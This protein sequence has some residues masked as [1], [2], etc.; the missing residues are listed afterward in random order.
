M[1]ESTELA[2]T[3]VT[4]IQMLESTELAPTRV[5][6]IQMLESTELAPTRVT[7]IQMLESTE[8]APTRVTE[9]QMLGEKTNFHESHG[10]SQRYKILGKV[11]LS[12]TDVLISKE[13]NFNYV[14]NPSKVC[15]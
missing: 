12:R 3:R 9:I 14:T 13:L 1:L 8:L 10:R 4:E 2:P 11:G 15:F 7:E 6:E 5:T